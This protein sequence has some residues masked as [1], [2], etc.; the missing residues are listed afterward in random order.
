LS[1]LIAFKKISIEQKSPG[2]TGLFSWSDTVLFV[3]DI[4]VCEIDTKL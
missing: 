2:K 4:G 1:Y 3:W